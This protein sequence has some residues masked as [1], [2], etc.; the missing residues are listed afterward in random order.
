MVPPRQC[1]SSSLGPEQGDCGSLNSATSTSLWTERP[2]L[3][4][5][6]STLSPVPSSEGTNMSHHKHQSP[7]HRLYQDPV[8]KT[9]LGSSQKPWHRVTQLHRGQ[10]NGSYL[11]CCRAGCTHPHQSHLHSPSPHHTGTPGPRTQCHHGRAHACEN[12]TDGEL[13]SRGVPGW[14]GGLG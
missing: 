8:P 13:G 11:G 3:S 14:T 10:K 9:P 7:G 12:R 2:T 4:F 5:S 1:I 6:N